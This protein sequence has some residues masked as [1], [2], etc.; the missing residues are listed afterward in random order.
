MD[1][2]FQSLPFPE[3]RRTHFHRFMHDVHAQL[4]TLRQTQ[5]PLEEVALRIAAGTRV[6]CFDELFVSDIGDA[7][8]LAG[9]FR[10]LIARGVTLVVTSNVPPHGLYKDGLQRQKFLPAIELLERHTEVI[11]VDGSVDYRLRQLTQAPIWLASSETTT[12]ARLAKLFDALADGGQVGTAPLEISGRRIPIVRESGAVVWFEFAAI[13]EGPRSQED[14]IE[15]ARDYQSVI[16]SGVPVLDETSENA[17]R[18]FVALVDEFYDHGVNLIASAAA[19][20][21]KLYRGERLKFEFQ[22]TAS[23]LIEMQSED[24]LGREHRA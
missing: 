2:F 18:R 23:R 16:V 21:N 9:L 8:I 10:A 14:Y 6:I 19:A 1:L 13:C 7:M 17:A 4:A 3:K 15:L 11:A 22:R 24:Y 12:P 20:P 5:S